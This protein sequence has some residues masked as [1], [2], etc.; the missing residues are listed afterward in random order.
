[1]KAKQSAKN[2][3]KNTKYSIEMDIT[4]GIESIGAIALFAVP[5][6]AFVIR[7]FWNKEKCFVAMK[8]AI[9]K[10][11]EHD[12]SS[13]DT[14]GDLYEKVNKIERNLFHMMGKMDITPVD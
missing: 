13:T 8:T 10:L 7:Y 5:P 11:T 6:S 4:I 12:G 1:M 14:H 9:D 2:V 3:G